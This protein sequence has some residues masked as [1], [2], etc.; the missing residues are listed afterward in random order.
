M[1]GLTKA[2]KRH[3]CDLCDGWIEPG[4]SYYVYQCTPW[5]GFNDVFGIWRTHKKC[6]DFANL[7]D[8]G[9][10]NEGQTSTWFEILLEEIYG[11]CI[12]RIFKEFTREDGRGC[13]MDYLPS[14]RNGEPY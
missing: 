10:L 9:S 7:H 4:E 11:R 12:Y 8:D 13:I 1:E 2:R 5:D 14:G 3:V 6:Q